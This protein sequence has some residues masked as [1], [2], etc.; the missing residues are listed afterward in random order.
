MIIT[1]SELFCSFVPTDKL[2]NW[3]VVMK[4]KRDSIICYLIELII[5]N[6]LRKTC[7]FYGYSVFFFTKK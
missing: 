1:N 2:L 5:V 7:D 6:S 3:M 4:Y